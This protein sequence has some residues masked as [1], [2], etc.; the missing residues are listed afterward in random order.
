MKKEAWKTY[1]RNL[2]RLAV[3]R[4]RMLGS[5]TVKDGTRV[6]SQPCAQRVIYCV[7]CG[8]PVVDDEIGRRRHSLKGA[9]CAAAM[10]IS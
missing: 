6:K 5:R 4:R 9:G 10:K 1:N 7:A 3:H 8:G 2:N